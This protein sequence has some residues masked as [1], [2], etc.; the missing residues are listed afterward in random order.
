MLP[1]PPEKEGYQ[2]IGWD[3]GVTNIQDNAVIN[4]V[5]TPNQYS[6]VFLDWDH[7]TIDT[8]TFQHG[9]MLQTPEPSEK[10]GSTFAG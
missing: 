7:R 4:A 8:K 5:Y 6:V 9:E 10:E 2:F 3:M 1:D